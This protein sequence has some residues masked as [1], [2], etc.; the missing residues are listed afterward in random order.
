MCVPHFYSVYRFIP[1]KSISKL[2]KSVLISLISDALL[3]EQLIY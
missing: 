3:I 1:N 2:K